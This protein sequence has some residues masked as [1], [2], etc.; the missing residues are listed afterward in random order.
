MLKKNGSFYGYGTDF[1][2]YIA[3]V[4]PLLSH[5]RVITKKSVE[6]SYLQP[7]LI[8]Q[9]RV[10]QCT[11]LPT[12]LLSQEVISR[13]TLVS[14]LKF[15]VDLIINNNIT[16]ELRMMEANQSSW[17]LYYIHLKLLKKSIWRLRF[18]EARGVTRD[19]HRKSPLHEIRN[20]RGKFLLWK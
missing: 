12:E 3:S 13:T 18:T 2:W 14:W 9:S 6:K 17:C 19:G 5:N 8:Q 16:F 20:R 4:F 1:V 15:N 11:A 10:C 7:N